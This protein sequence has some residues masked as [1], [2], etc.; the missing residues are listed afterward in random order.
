[1]KGEL[2]AFTDWDIGRLAD[3][4]TVFSA[5]NVV[6]GKGNIVASRKHARE[7]SG[8]V[9]EAFLGLGENGHAGEEKLADALAADARA[10]AMRIADAI[11][12]QPPIGAAALAAV[13]E[14]V[15]Q[16]PA[17][18]RLRRRLC[19]VGPRRVALTDRPP[20]FSPRSRSA[21]GCFNIGVVTGTEIPADRVAQIVPG[22]TT[23]DEILRWFGAPYEATD[24]EVLAR[25]FDA[26]EIAAE[27]LVA[28]PFND[29]LAFE[30]LEGDAKILMTIVFNW[31][32]VDVK[33]DRLV[34]F[35]DERDGC[36]TTASR[37]SASRSR[38]LPRPRNRTGA[39]KIQ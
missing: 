6:T 39:R 16:A 2:F 8:K 7:V 30:I 28:L 10:D 27:D 5:G 35:F 4:P 1:M 25:M 22:E 17:G 26:G 19:R 3:Y 38:P 9:M 32:R 37:A 24:G 15:S 33:R 29:M 36:S 21:C 31:A 13:R 34:V 11:S 20:S 14:R 12:V 18:G 23:K